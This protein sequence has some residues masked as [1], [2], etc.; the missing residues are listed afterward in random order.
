MCLL[1]A[2][3]INNTSLLN[4]QLIFYTAH[5]KFYFILCLWLPLND[6]NFIGFFQQILP[7]NMHKDV[8]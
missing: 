6:E 1:F 7:L 8:R 5:L 4:Y 3:K 2:L